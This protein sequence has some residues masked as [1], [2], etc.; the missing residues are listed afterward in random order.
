VEHVAIDLGGR[1]SQVCIRSKKGEVLLER[2]VATSSLSRLLKQR[3]QSRVVVETCAEAFHVADAA[4]ELGHEVRVV[5]AMLVR[6]LGVGA[7]GVKTDERDARA[8]SE[9]ST[10]IDLPSVHVPSHES[11]DR[12]SLCSLRDALVSSRTQMIN[13]VR[14]WMRARM[15]KARTG[16][17]ETFCERV[18]QAASTIELPR[19][20]V[21]QLEAIEQMTAHIAEA[22]KELEALADKDPT[23]PRLMSVPGVGPVT[24]I[25]FVAALDEISRFPSVAQVQ[26]YLGLT[27]GENSSSERQRRTGITKAGPPALRASLIQAAWAARRTRGK[28]PMLDWVIEVEKRRGKHV[29][30]VALAR[31]LSAILFA[32][33]RDG[34]FYNPKNDIDTESSMPS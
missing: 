6:S 17:T 16:K 15:I 18:R 24:A 26:S 11:R 8:L 12:K 29:A 1:Q 34:T 32:L 3:P 10:R 33:W 22:D 30:I 5:P 21:R 9:V 7:R 27:P 31:K 19:Y 20:V 28:H 23:C 4:V 25:R 14:G 2:R 13:T